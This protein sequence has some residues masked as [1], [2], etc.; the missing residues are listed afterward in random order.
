MRGQAI[1]GGGLLLVL[2][3]VAFKFYDSGSLDDF[4]FVQRIQDIGS[5][6][7]DSLSER[8]YFILSEI[9]AP[10]FVFGRGSEAVKEIVG[11]EVHSTVASYFACYGYVVGLGFIFFLLLWARHLVRHDGLLGALLVF[12]PPMMYGITHNGSRFT[13]F[14]IL[15]AASMSVGE[16]RNVRPSLQGG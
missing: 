7:D 11:H 14:W 9:D 2:F 8:C 15:I 6:D 1:I 3:L 16:P 13:V 4:K 10:T 5:Q 12:A